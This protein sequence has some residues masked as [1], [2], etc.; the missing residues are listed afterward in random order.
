MTHS[1]KNAILFRVIFMELWD[2]YD[3]DRMPT[4]KTVVRG[5]KAPEGLYHMVVHAAIFDPDGRLLI[6]RRCAQKKTF[7]LKWDVT[8]GGSALV[9]ETSREAVRRELNEELGI[10]ID[11]S[12]MRPRLTVNFEQGFDDFY[13]VVCHEE[14]SSLRFQA[15][16]VMDARLA[17]LDEINAM[18]DS[19]E[20]VP[21]MKSFIALLFEMKDSVDNLT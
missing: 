18:I 8:V 14:L 9:G 12:E 16:E 6:Q 10:D 19:G 1:A 20:F 15:E 13:I 4:G 21:Y 17:T 7:A 11:F 2:G 3:I 5:E